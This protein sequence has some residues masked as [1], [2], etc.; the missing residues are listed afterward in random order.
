VII[1]KTGYEQIPQSDRPL[2]GFSRKVFWGF[3][4]TLPLVEHPKAERD[5]P[6]DDPQWLI[7]QLIKR[8]HD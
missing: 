6:L 5:L 7:D 4:K 3:D 2:Y 1:V 8:K